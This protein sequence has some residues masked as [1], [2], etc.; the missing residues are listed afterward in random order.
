MC[1]FDVHVRSS[2]GVALD[3]IGSGDVSSTLGSREF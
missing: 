3:R 2:V 1:L